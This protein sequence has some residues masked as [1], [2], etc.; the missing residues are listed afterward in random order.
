MDRSDNGRLDHVFEKSFKA[1]IWKYYS[2]NKTKLFIH[3]F[4]INFL[5]QNTERLSTDVFSLFLMNITKK[6]T[7]SNILSKSSF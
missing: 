4:K 2:E 6:V 3:S 1:K 5:F 7:G